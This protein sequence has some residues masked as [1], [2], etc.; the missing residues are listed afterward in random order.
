MRD[1]SDQFCDDQIKKFVN[2]EYRMDE[3]VRQEKIAEW[4]S[5]KEEIRKIIDE[6]I[7]VG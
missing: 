4:K 7:A 5:N 2:N 6:L 1:A 3:P